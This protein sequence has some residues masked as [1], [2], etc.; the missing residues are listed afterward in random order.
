VQPMA[1]HTLLLAGHT[2]SL[3]YLAIWP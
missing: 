3:L 1:H 2:H